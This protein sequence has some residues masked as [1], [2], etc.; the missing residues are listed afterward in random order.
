MVQ[1]LNYPHSKPAGKWTKFKHH[2]MF[3]SKMYCVSIVSILVSSGLLS[4]LPLH[5]VVVDNYLAVFSSLMW[6]GIF[7]Q[8]PAPALTDDENGGQR[9]IGRFQKDVILFYRH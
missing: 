1:S 6:T 5:T 3:L 4:R 7:P 8:H 2:S 9:I